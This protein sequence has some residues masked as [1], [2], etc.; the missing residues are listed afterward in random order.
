VDPRSE[1][2]PKGVDVSQPSAARVYDY[3]LGGACNFAVDRELAQQVAK[4]V[5]WVNDTARENRRFLRRAVR[6]CVNNGIRQFVDIGSGT[7]TV[8][9]V[10]EVALEMDPSCR[11][12][13]VDNEPVAVAHSQLLLE[14]H[15]NVGVVRA[16]LRDP[17][18]VLGAEKTRALIDFDEP[19]AI[20]MVALL[21]FIP[22]EENPVEVIGRYRDAVA[23][24]SYLAVSHVTEDVF[25]DQI[26]KLVE[27]YEDSANPVTARTH[28]DVMRLFAAFELVDPGL[29]WT[30]SWRPEPGDPIRPDPESCAIYAGVGRK[31][32]PVSPEQD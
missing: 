18:A 24:G 29:V 16:D 8:G 22:D 17:D 25:G 12:V 13:Y 30:A 7:P 20:L 32:H 10:H 14:G 19:V 15:D 26:R 4:A 21:H 11:V 9:N 23:P 31:P 5:P 1:Q 3:Y 6:Y 28:D 2:V 27:V